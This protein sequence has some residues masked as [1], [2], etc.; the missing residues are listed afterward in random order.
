MSKSFTE[1]Q[2]AEIR[3]HFEY[4]DRDE[5]GCMEIKEFRELFKIIAPESKRA[6]ADD[7][8]SAIDE[9]G[10]GAI[11]FDEFLEWWSHNWSVY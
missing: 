10:N 11:D 4:F 7:A 5:S 8:F 2:I 9:D 3:N 1:E 6:E